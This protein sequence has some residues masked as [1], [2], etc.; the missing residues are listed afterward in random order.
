MWLSSL[1]M[2]A[3]TLNSV[4]PGRVIFEP[5]TLTCLGF[6]WEM[7]GDANR[8]AS[9][10]AAYRQG[11]AAEWKGSAAAG[12]N[13]RGTSRASR[14]T[15]GLHGSSQVCRQYS[16][17]RGC[18]RSPRGLVNCLRLCW[19]PALDALPGAPPALA[20]A[21]LLARRR[22][23]IALLRLPP[24]P[25]P[26]LLPAALAATAPPRLARSFGLFRRGWTA[27]RRRPWPLRRAHGRPPLPEAPAREGKVTPLRGAVHLRLTAKS[28]LSRKT[29][30]AIARR[31]GLLSGSP[32]PGSSYRLPGSFLDST[33]RS[34]L[35]SAEGAPLGAKAPRGA[36]VA[37]APSSLGSC[38][39]L[40]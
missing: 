2:A 5:P 6:E 37:V 31:R 30:G 14:G 20:V 26:R 22:F 13:G 40:K 18:A 4:R 39:L 24:R 1:V 29:H 8:N 36:A 7:E 9:V 19:F 16:A 10:E 33:G 27:R 25:S 34:L 35:E 32:A 28:T 3:A 21:P 17:G 15:A 12:S 38:I 23:P 11:G